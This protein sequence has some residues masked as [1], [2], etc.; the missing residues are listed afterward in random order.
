[1]MH[2]DDIQRESFRIIEAEVG[3]HN[4]SPE[5]WLVTRRVIHST[6]DFEYA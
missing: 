4:L 2:P 6:G 5:Q 1:M 3:P